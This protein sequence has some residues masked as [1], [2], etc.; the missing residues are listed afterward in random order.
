LVSKHNIIFFRNTDRN[1]LNSFVRTAGSTFNI[2]TSAIERNGVDQNQVANLVQSGTQFIQR[3]P[4]IVQDGV[5]AVQDG[6]RNAGNG[7]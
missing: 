5:K 6:V 7:T 4:Q 3:H 2:D 1:Q